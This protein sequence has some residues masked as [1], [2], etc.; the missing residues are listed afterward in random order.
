MEGKVE[1]PGTASVKSTDLE[2]T[3]EARGG[4]IAI[5]R[6]IGGTDLGVGS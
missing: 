6:H 2:K 5:Y 1:T 3:V 4:S